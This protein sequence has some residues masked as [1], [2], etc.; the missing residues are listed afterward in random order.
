AVLFGL[1]PALQATRPSVAETIK[2]ENATAKPGRRLTMRSALVVGQ[3]ATSLVLLVTAALFLRSFAAQSRIDPGFGSAPAGLVWIGIPT[4]RVPGERR[5]L[6]IEE[7]GRRMRDLSG[8]EA[9][10]LID[11]LMLNPLSQQS[12]GITVEG[13]VPPKGER[14]FNI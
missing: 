4:D 9:V 14:G 13:F 6:L 12:R 1:L 10:G 8:V 2:N 7:I 11:N 3:T 5:Q